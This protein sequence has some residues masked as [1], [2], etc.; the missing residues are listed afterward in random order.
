MAAAD[1][2]RLFAAISLALALSGAQA[3]VPLQQP[4]WNELSAEQRLVLE[5]LAGSWD[6]L[7]ADRKKKWLTLSQ[8]Y[9]SMTPEEKNRVRQRMHEWARLS[10]AERKAARDNFTALQRAPAE[11]RS[12][13]KETLKQQWSQYDS[14]AESEKNRLRAEGSP[15][16]TPS[17]PPAP[18]STR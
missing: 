7:D 12:G 15:V 3:V 9:A 14:L 5:P 11:Q 6:T 13:M 18:A 10:P 8:R 16:V 2:L 1:L 4:S 17:K